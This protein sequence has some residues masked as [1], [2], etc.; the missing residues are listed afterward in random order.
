MTYKHVKCSTNA[1]VVISTQR[2]KAKKSAG[3]SPLCT[4]LDNF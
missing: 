4:K 2:H 1:W 3:C